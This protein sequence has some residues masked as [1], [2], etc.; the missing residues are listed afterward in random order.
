MQLSSI[1]LHNK[2]Q[3][4]YQDQLGHLPITYKLDRQ[5]R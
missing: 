4:D 1:H 2:G 5:G 3:I